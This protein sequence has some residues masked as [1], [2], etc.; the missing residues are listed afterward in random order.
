[1]AADRGRAPSC[2]AA[3][4]ASARR[5][6]GRRRLKAPASAAIASSPRAQRRL[7]RGSRWRALTTY[8][9]SSSR[10]PRASCRRRSRLPSTWPSCAPMSGMADP[11]LG[12]VTGGAG[13]RPRCSQERP[14]ALAIDDVQWL[15]DSTAGVLRFALRR[16]E[17]EPVIV[18]ATERSSTDA[19]LPDAVADLSLE[20]V[21]R[22]SVSPLGPEATDRL[23]DESLGLRLAP[24]LLRRCTGCRAATPSMPS[25]SGGWSGATEGEGGRRDR[26]ARLAD[27][28]PSGAPRASVAR[29][30]RRVGPR[31]GAVA[32]NDPADRGGARS[33]ARSLRARRRQAPP[34]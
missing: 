15:D 7:R 14:L 22:V 12:A 23:L 20:R 11:A 9:A 19:T 5:R 25:R 3:W 1:M 28:P 2:S 31:R 8:S 33:R 29:R 4:P 16:V 6:C 27:R 10:S 30:P 17:Q 13:A 34:C 21:T 24:T 18:I 26:A 32:A